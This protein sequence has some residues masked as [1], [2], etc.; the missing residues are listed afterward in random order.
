MKPGGHPLEE[1]ELAILRV[2]V[3]QP[4]SLLGQIKEDTRG[5]LRAVRRVL[6]EGS[7]LL[8]VVDQ[9]EELFT[10]VRDPGE[11]QF[12]PGAASTRR[13]VIRRVPCGWWSRCGRITTTGR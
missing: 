6:P 5:T 11:S 1:L 3:T 13:S 9:L 12:L 7:Q 10:L 2:A 8:L 4:P